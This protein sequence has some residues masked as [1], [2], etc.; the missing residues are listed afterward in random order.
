MR[1]P[2][3]LQAQLVS[4]ANAADRANRPAAFVLLPGVGVAIALV[5][6]LVLFAR[7]TAARRD[8]Q[9][10]Q[11]DWVTIQAT[12]EE[13]Q[14]RR[15][16]SPDLAAVFPKNALF[17]SIVEDAAEAAWGLPSGELPITVG[18]PRSSNFFATN[19]DLVKTDVMCTLRTV[20]LDKL[21]AWVDAV[22]HAQH[23]R[24]V[25]LSKLELQPT[26]GGW[27]G[28]VVFRRYEYDPS[29]SGR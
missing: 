11:R 4:A 16:T 13:L 5:V 9:V 21:E 14:K 18:Q 27:N 24:G 7:F 26:S 1:W 12:I 25:F 19:V 22:L 29:Q 10:Q 28:Q 20:P 15:T 23:L 6:L 17:D 8:L 3:Q 2:A